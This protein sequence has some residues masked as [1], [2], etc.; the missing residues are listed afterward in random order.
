M[1]RFRLSPSLTL[2]RLHYENQIPKI[3][4]WTQVTFKDKGHTSKTRPLTTPVHS[5]RVPAQRDLHVPH[6]PPQP[7][8]SG[9]Y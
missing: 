4:C 7:L 5:A 6:V 1:N 2:T 8:P 9:Q 3:K